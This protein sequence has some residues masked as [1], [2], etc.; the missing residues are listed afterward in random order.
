MK[1]N[2]KINIKCQNFG[3]VQLEH[4]ISPLHRTNESN[5]NIIRL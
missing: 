5:K 4:R 2:D 1:I 3:V